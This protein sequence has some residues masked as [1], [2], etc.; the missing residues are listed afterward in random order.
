MK[1]AQIYIIHE[2]EEWSQPLFSWLDKLGLPYQSWFLNEGD[3][4]LSQAPP[5]GIFY[6]RMSASSHSRG[7]RYAI[8]LAETVLGWLEAH[9]RRVV[10]SPKALFAEVRKAEQLIA[11]QKFGIPVPRSVVANNPHALLK[12]AKQFPASF[13]VKPNRGGKGLGVKLYQGSQQLA[14]D[15]ANN[16]A[17]QSLDGILI[18][19]EYI[20]PKDGR[21]TRVELIG[22]KFYYAV[23]VDASDGFELCPADSC[24]IED[25]L[26]PADANESDSANPRFKILEEYDN[27]DLLAYEA[28]FQDMGISVGALEY[29]QGADGKRY[30]Y[31][32]NSNTNYN[33]AAEA[34]AGDKRQGMRQLAEY[35]GQELAWLQYS[36][37]P[38]PVGLGLPVLHWH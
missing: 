16:T 22:G 20:A 23:S 5:E 36:R 33:A 19:Q 15:L 7:H 32:I 28:L 12:A 26:C 10:N 14:E 25:L 38:V 2:N 31:D 37:Q 1:N 17:P 30:V 21:I 29:A 24:G 4:D 13:I 18:V 8:E 34:A 35:L 3:L 27:P 11:L 6:N 9:G